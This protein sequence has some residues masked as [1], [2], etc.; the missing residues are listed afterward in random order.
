MG[1]GFPKKNFPSEHGNLMVK[2]EVLFPPKLGKEQRKCVEG[3]S[4]VVV[5][6][7]VVVVEQ[8]SSGGGGSGGGCGVY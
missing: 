5:V 8:D 7:V 1:E 3:W 2:F 4:K 6:V